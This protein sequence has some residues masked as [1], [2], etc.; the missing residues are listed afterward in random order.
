MSRPFLA[1]LVASILAAGQQP[2]PIAADVRAAMEKIDRALGVECTHCHVQDQWRDDSKEA[3][4]TAK[5][6]MAMVKAVN[7][8]LSEIGSVSCWTCHAGQQKPSRLPGDKLAAEQAK[9]PAGVPED[10]KLAMAVYDVTLGVGCEHC[11]D[12]ADWKNADKPA[13]KRVPRMTALFDLFPKYMPAAAR[14]QCF[15]CHKGRTKPQ[16]DYNAGP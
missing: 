7:G 10:R 8:Q 5:N 16:S 2:A 3:F 6:M 12:P 13:M 14:P 9:W 1:A 4:A 15:M 11:H